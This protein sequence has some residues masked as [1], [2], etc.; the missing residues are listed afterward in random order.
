LTL[1]L[2][3]VAFVYPLVICYHDFLLLFAP[4]S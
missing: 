3:T 4:T 1:Y 2:W